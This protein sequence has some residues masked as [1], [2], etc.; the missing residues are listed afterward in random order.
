MGLELLHQKRL[1]SVNEIRIG[2][3]AMKWG[4]VFKI[5]ATLFLMVI[6]IAVLFIGIAVGIAMGSSAT[7]KRLN[8]E[9][10]DYKLKLQLNDLKLQQAERVLDIMIN[11]KCTDPVIYNAIMQTFDPILIA[12][13]IDAESD[14]YVDCVS[15]KGCRGLMQLSPDKLDDWTDPEKNIKVGA[16]YLKEQLDYF[17]VLELALAAYNAGPTKVIKCGYQIPDIPETQQYVKNIMAMGVA[18]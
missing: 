16:A 5:K 3:E 15:D 9:I 14:Y 1:T 13:V 11:N 7:E 4:I 18:I 10:E 8:L 17:G 12:K 6:S 2:G